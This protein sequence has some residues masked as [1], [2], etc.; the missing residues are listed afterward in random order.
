MSETQ[1]KLSKAAMV[2]LCVL[3]LLGVVGGWYI[4]LNGG[5]YHQNGKYSHDFT[6][7]G[8]PMA[9]VMVAIEFS[10]TGIGVAA[11]VQYS[12]AAKLWYVVGCCAV[13]VPP[14]LFLLLGYFSQ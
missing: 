1:S 6:Y 3:T 9:L 10:M 7:V 8:G 13:L 4:L 12:N 11:I 14:A 2:S 5:F